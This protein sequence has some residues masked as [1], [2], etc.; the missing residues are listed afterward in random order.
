MANILYDLIIPKVL[1]NYVR[2]FDNEVLRPQAQWNL[3]TWLPNVLTDDLDFRI[4][5]GT[6]QDVDIAE[7]RA[8]D[9]P[10]RMTGRPGVSIIQGSLGP[11]SRQIPLGEEEYL[12]SKTLMSGNNDPI[13]QAIYQDSERM[14]RAVQGRI[15]MARGDLIDDGKVQIAENGLTLTADFGRQSLMRKTA[16]TLWTTTATATPLSDLLSWQMDYLTVNGM[17]PATMLI[18]LVRISSLALN[19]E[20]RNYAA[21][22]GTVPQRLNRAA[23]NDVFANEGLPLLQIF[24]EQVRKDG[25]VTRVLAVNKVFLMPPPSEPLGATF[26]GV[27][28]EAQLLQSKGYIDATEA[29]GVVAVVTHTEH[30]VQTYTVGTA[31]ALPA[32][33]NPDLVLDAVVA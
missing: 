11:V 4:R 6:F 5:K 22:N 29:P 32:M 15:E 19:V 3:D 8:W 28:A 10:A 16:G 24:D 18:P 33:P 30:P 31:I 20:M 23:I 1:I 9:T 26:Y 12:R 25:A 2:A 17:V 7:Y 27:T 21:A 13:I 14:M